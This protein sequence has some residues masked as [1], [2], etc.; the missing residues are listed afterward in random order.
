MAT[1]RCSINSL[2]LYGT[3]MGNSNQH[4][5]YD[6]PHMLV[7]GAN[8]KLKGQPP[9]RLRA[10]DGDDRKPAARTCWTCTASTRT[11]RATA[12]TGWPSCSQTRKRRISKSHARCNY[13][14]T[15]P[16]KKTFCVFVFSC[17]RGCFVCAATMVTPRPARATSPTRSMKGDKAA[18]RALLQQ[19]ADVNAPQSR[20]RDRAALGRLSRRPR[21]GGPPDRRRRQSRRRQPRGGHAAGDGLAVRQRADDRTAAEGRRRSEAAPRPTARRC[22]CWRRATAIPRRSRCSSAAGADVNAKETVR[23]TTALMWAAEQ[24]HPA[25]VKALLELRR[26][27]TAPSPGRPACRATTWRRA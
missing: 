15:K 3:N 22:S 16:S 12:R 19:K 20:R 9:R 1:A 25:A 14:D 4:Q 2:I 11:S 18:L 8:G 5:H 24:R 7:G 6:V 27:F 21:D 23:G 10:Q 17:F 26:R 13:E